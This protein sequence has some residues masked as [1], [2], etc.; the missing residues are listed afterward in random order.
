MFGV[1]LVNDWSAGRAGLGV[2]AARAVSRQKLRHDS[3]AVGRHARRARAVPRAGIQACGGRPR[4]APVSGVYVKRDVRGLRHPAR[5]VDSIGTHACGWNVGV[6]SESCAL[7]GDVL[8]AR[9]A[10]HAPCE[11]RV[12]SRAGR[13]ARQ[14]Y[15]LRRLEGF[16]RMFAGVDVARDRAHHPC[17]RANSVAIS[18]TATRSSFAGFCERD[19]FARI[20]FGECRERCSPKRLIR[21]H[22]IGTRQCKRSKHPTRQRLRAT[23]TGDRAQRPRVRRGPDPH[24]PEGPQPSCRLDRGADGAY[25]AKRRGHSG[26]CGSGLDRVLQMT[27]YISD[28]ELWAGSTWRTRA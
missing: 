1:C 14:R 20:G 18:R 16:P 27:I 12:Q 9:A 11:Q 25:A 21:H 13:F 4:S 10:G 15:G 23:T 2:S 6:S 3:L 22:F 5:S 24:R 17:R 26:G 19:G 7:H 28:I 8:D